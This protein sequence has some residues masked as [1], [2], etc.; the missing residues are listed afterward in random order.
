M[1]SATIDSLSAYLLTQPFCMKGALGVAWLPGVDDAVRTV[2]LH[3]TMSSHSDGDESDL[4]AHTRPE[5]C[6]GKR[7]LGTRSLLPG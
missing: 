5:E 6:P 1:G 4:G 7:E 2:V 3:Q